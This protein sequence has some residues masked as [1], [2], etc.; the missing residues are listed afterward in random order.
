MEVPYPLGDVVRSKSKEILQNDWLPEGYEFIRFRLP[1]KNS[2]FLR[3]VS[4]GTVEEY[5]KAE[6][7]DKKDYLLKRLKKEMLDFLEDEST[8][9]PR[10]ISE[11]LKNIT[12]KKLTEGEI[13]YV[14]EEDRREKIEQLDWEGLKIYIPNNGSILGSVFSFSTLREKEAYPFFGAEIRKEYKPTSNLFD[15]SNFDYISEYMVYR[16]IY[17]LAKNELQGIAKE[18]EDDK[19]RC[20]YALSEAAKLKIY[21]KNMESIAPDSVVETI[22]TRN[23]YTYRDF[24]LRNFSSILRM[25]I[26][27]LKAWSDN[28]SVHRYIYTDESFPTL[29]IFIVS[30]GYYGLEG[31]YTDV[32]YLPGGITY[33]SG[34]KER[35]K[36]YL[37][38]KEDELL[39]YQLLKYDVTNNARIMEMNYGVYLDQRKSNTSTLTSM[40]TDLEEISI[41]EYGALEKILEEKGNVDEI[42]KLI[43]DLE[44]A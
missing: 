38:P 41:P 11:K 31:I 21:R 9:T 29:L 5:R 36:Y 22:Q 12:L 34:E 14:N 28:V 6:K 3:S 1:E 39:I 43:D 13:S 2:M 30:E 16:I 18:L 15:L 17:R 4:Y 8:Y 19:L 42:G 40:L 23:N 33:K 32:K 44:L 10:E 24:E 27:L 20:E 26:C 37:E 7:E 35:V 25:N